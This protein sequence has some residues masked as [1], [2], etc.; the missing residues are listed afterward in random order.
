MV[1]LAAE[2]AKHADTILLDADPQGNASV[3]IGLETL[4]AE[5]ASVLFKKYSLQN[6]VVATATEHLSLLSSAGPG[7]N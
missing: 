5:V 6:A 1:S 3:W 7:G 4:K 2:L